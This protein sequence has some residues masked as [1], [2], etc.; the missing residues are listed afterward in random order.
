GWDVDETI[1]VDLDV[2]LNFWGRLALAQA[3]PP[4]DWDE[5]SDFRDVWRHETWANWNGRPPA[6][7]DL[8]FKG[9]SLRTADGE[10]VPA[11]IEDATVM[12]VGRT[13][14]S[15]PTATQGIIRVRATF[16]VRELP[17][18][19][20]QVLAGRLTAKPN[21][22]DAPRHPANVM[23]NEHLRVEI[24]PNGTL[25]I[26]DK[27]TGQRFTDLGYFEDGGDCGDGYT[28]SY[29]PHDAVITTLGARPRILRL[30]DGP[31]VQRYRI[32]YDLELPVGLTDDRKRRRAETVHCPL[33]VTVS[34]GAHAR[35]VDFEVTLENRAKDHR[36]RVVFPS[37]V[38]TDVSFSEGQFDV[39]PH[40]VHPGQ[41]PIDIWQEDQPTTYPQQT[42]VDVSDGQRGLCVMNHGLPEYEVIN[43]PRR[44]IAITLLRAVAYLG[45]AHHLYTA[46]RGAGP[47][48][49]T[50]GAQCLRALTYRYAVMP[51]A[52]TWDQAEVWR[53]AHTHDVRPRAI[54]VEKV[55]DFPIPVSPTPAGIEVPRDRHSF[56]SVE[57]HNAVLSAVKRADREDA[58]IVR[59]FNPSTEPTRATIR[60]AAGLTGA[61][62]VNLNEEPLGDP[63]PIRDGHEIE[64]D[65]APKRIV[66]VKAIPEIA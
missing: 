59:L 30:S 45:G 58:L 33:T 1:T 23:E 8:N 62:M 38:K 14:L 20:Y 44:E 42:F 19:G 5:N 29:P 39:V 54:V 60:F 16:P 12:G 61:E 52:G 40:P 10:E 28:Y 49:F 24:Q 32:E 6:L 3:H 22:Y 63:L 47:H 7:P 37:D 56:L 64:V 48:I 17:A 55:P 41:P 18:Y 65:L 43:S 26:T 2:P 25:C 21:K 51:H 27:A 31:I 9:L 36:L 46:H 53:E 50:P 34:L 13:L 66:T 4:R 11:Q 57:G 35:R 15:G